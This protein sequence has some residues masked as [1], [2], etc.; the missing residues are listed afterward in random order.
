MF[1]NTL[2]FALGILS[3]YDIFHATAAGL[4]SFACNEFAFPLFFRSDDDDVLYETYAAMF[5]YRL[6]TGCYTRTKRITEMG[7]FFP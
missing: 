5:S 6:V 4:M 1:A 7:E 3:C 2:G